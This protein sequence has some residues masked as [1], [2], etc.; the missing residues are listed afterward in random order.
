MRYYLFEEYDE[1]KEPEKKYKDYVWRTAI[2]LQQVDGLEPSEYLLLTAQKNING[3]ISFTEA[4]ELIDSFYQF[5]L[6]RE[7]TRTEEADKVSTRIA[8]ILFERSFV[9]SPEQYISIHKRLFEGIY[10]FAGQI[11][12][13]NIT[14]EEWVLGG[15]TVI[16]GNALD[17]R[18]MLDY[19]L[20][21]EKEFSYRGLSSEQMIEH[22][23]RFV[24]NLWQIHAFGEGNTRTTAVFLIEYLRTLGFD[25]ENDLFAKNAWYFRNALVRANYT[26]VQKDIYET[27]EYLE[28]FLRNL[29]LGEHNELKNRHLHINTSKKQYIDDENQY[30]EALKMAHCNSKTISNVKKMY[31]HF[32]KNTIFG[33]S[34]VVELLN[35]TSSPASTLIKK[36]SELDI[37][38]PVSGQGKGKYIFNSQIALQ[39]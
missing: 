4:K 26:N 20:G 18:K 21:L 6:D 15:D 12:D 1:I 8:E 22:L 31:E 3:N 37:I 24:S 5:K 17:L 11:R 19:D 23:A 29:L 14:K 2:G 27:T 25:V 28:L 13:Y 39:L 36:L 38:I 10:R 9:F 7:D 16:Y 35:I 33:R 34:D 32:G 30:I